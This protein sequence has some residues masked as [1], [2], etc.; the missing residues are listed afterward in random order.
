MAGSTLVAARTWL[1]VLRCG[2]K[3]KGESRM[4]AKVCG[5]RGRN[6]VV[7]TMQAHVVTVVMIVAVVV[8]K[9]NV[10]KEKSVRRVKVWRLCGWKD[11][12][13]VMMEGS[14]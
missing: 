11:E 1:A 9:V 6:V 12:M 8:M 3:D 10:M 13:V 14:K 5:G 4:D 2:V 7:V